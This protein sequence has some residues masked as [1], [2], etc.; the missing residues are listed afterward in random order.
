MDDYNQLKLT[1]ESVPKN[2][3][4]KIKQINTHKMFTGCRRKL[5]L[6]CASSDI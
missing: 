6:I 1:A 3:V 5:K 4:G 2:G